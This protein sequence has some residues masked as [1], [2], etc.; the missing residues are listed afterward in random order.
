[1]IVPAFVACMLVFTIALSTPV[2]RAERPLMATVEADLVMDPLGWVGT[3]SGDISGTIV[4]V[5]NPAV[6]VGVT[7]HFDES[8][9]LTTTDGVVI[10]GYDLGLFNLNTLKFSANGGITE[11]SSPDW[12]WLVGYELHFWGSADLS[13]DPW[14]VTGY[15]RMMAP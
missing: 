15:V 7:E 11:V 8:F 10:E 6:F 1:M 9:T 2:A 14:H 12:E 13:V 4:I 5:E 3:V